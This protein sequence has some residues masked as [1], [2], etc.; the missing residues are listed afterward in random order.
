MYDNYKIKKSKWSCNGFP[1]DE[2]KIVGIGLKAEGKS[3]GHQRMSEKS[4]MDGRSV[5]LGQVGIKY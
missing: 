5:F 4:M 1:R 3:S 2:Q